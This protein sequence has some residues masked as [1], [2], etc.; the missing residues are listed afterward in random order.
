M[1]ITKEQFIKDTKARNAAAW[2]HHVTSRPAYEGMTVKD[3]K[4]LADE[5]HEWHMQFAWDFHLGLSS[6]EARD[7]CNS[8]VNPSDQGNANG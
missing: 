6:I 4:A 1:A 2:F 5:M 8:T 7:I 3:A